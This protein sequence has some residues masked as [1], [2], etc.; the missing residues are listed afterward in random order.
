MPPGFSEYLSM[1]KSATNLDNPPCN[2]L[3]SVEPLEMLKYLSSETK[4]TIFLFVYWEGNQVADELYFC[5]CSNI[6][7]ARDTNKHNRCSQKYPPC[8]PRVRCR[9]PSLN[10]P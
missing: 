3:H 7:G 1:T 9:P 6:L 8:R 4:I 5:S 2:F 10:L